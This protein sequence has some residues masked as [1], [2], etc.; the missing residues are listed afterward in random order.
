MNVLQG[1]I[2]ELDLKNE[3]LNTQI[4]SKSQEI[5]RLQREKERAQMVFDEQNEEL[6]KVKGERQLLID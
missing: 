1:K 6:I 2:D 5:D 3:Q 4:N